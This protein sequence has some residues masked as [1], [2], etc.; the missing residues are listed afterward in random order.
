MTTVS[1]VRFMYPLPSLKIQQI[2][3]ITFDSICIR[4]FYIICMMQ[5]WLFKVWKWAESFQVQIILH[6][7]VRNPYMSKN[8]S[9]IQIPIKIQADSWSK[10]LTKTDLF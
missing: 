10:F 1:S 3:F 6:A 4:Y 5:I 9:Q 7:L 8:W 2:K